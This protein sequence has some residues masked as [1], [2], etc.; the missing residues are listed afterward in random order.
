MKVCVLASGSKG[1][2][3][4]IKSGDTSILIDC[5][6]SAKKVAESLNELGEEASA[7]SGILITHEHTDH[8]A[9]LKD[10]CGRYRI[11]VYVHEKG[12]EALVG[13][14]GI[15][16]R[17]LRPY[18]GALPIGDLF[19]EYLPLS[20]DAACCVGYKLTGVRGSICTVTDTGCFPEGAE[21]FFKDSTLAVLESNHDRT[22][23][24]KGNYPERLKA[25]IMGLKGHLSNE[26]A[27]QMLL[28][29]PEMGVKEVWLGHISENNNTEELA[30]SVSLEAL[31]SNGICEGRD[32]EVKTLVQR[33]R[34]LYKDVG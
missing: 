33:K 27:A 8:I 7:L 14:S 18:V 2:S 16:V 23:L 3:T 31:K 30:M 19:M 26:Q 4:F 9:G 15:D 21:N 12:A 28:K 5:G 10:F 25:R 1:N 32:I 6:L 24:I 20:H 34:S 22:M 17:L 13:R 29:L 11:P